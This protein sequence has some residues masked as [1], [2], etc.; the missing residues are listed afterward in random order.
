MKYTVKIHLGEE[1]VIPKTD[2]KVKLI[3]FDV[4]YAGKRYDNSSVCFYNTLIIR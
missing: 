3:F 2:L 1:L 4:Y